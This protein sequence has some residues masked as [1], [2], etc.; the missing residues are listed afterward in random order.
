MHGDKKTSHLIGRSLNQV[1]WP[2]DVLVGAVIRSGELVVLNEQCVIEEA[3]HIV[4]VL[5]KRKQLKEVEK[6]FQVSAD[7]F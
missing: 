3:D 6:L 5:G 7:F 1:P 2:K 4:L